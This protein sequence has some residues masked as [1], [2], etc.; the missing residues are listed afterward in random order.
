MAETTPVLGRNTIPQKKKTI[1]R[2]P[3]KQGTQKLSNKMKNFVKLKIKSILMIN[4]TIR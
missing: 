3:V 4:A 1:S 2:T